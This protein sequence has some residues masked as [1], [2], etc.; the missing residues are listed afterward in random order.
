MSPEKNPKFYFWVTEKGNLN[1]MKLF[2][3]IFD[4]LFSQEERDNDSQR[5]MNR[6]HEFLMLIFSSREI[7][8]PRIEKIRFNE[9]K[10]F[11]TVKNFLPFTYHDSRQ[12]V[13]K[14]ERKCS[15][16][17]F[18]LPHSRAKWASAAVNVFIMSPPRPQ[19]ASSSSSLARSLCSRI[20]MWASIIRVIEKSSFFTSQPTRVVWL[21][22]EV[23][24]RW[25]ADGDDENA[26]HEKKERVIL[27]T[28]NTGWN[29]TMKCAGEA[30]SENLFMAERM[31][32]K[33]MNEN[34]DWIL[35]HF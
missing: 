32:E 7:F 20:K 8:Y 11:V 10:N 21:G 22:G 5:P 9:I 4:L 14:N 6:S 12:L 13:S 30:N 19:S 33:E 35:K 23:E 3:R 25:W 24:K 17:N 34:V 29:T 28:G 1:F 18:K 27:Q 15:D 26:P 16:K 2:F 31:R